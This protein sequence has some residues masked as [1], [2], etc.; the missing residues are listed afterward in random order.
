MGCCVGFAAIKTEIEAVVA[1]FHPTDAKTFVAHRSGMDGLNY[2]VHLGVVV[3]PDVD[4]NTQMFE[5][6]KKL[7]SR[8]DL[9]VKMLS[10]DI[11]FKDEKLIDLFLLEI[12]TEIA[13]T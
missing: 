8:T 12:E 9:C 13:L 7:E 10:S 2:K 1:Q 11:N 6:L 3:K 5:A 4:K